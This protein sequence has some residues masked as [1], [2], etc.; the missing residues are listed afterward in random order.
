MAHILFSWLLAFA[1]CLE[2]HRL[3]DPPP[4]SS[5]TMGRRPLGV[6][7]HQLQLERTIWATATPI[8]TGPEA[9]KTGDISTLHTLSTG[10]ECDGA[11][12]IGTPAPYISCYTKQMWL[13]SHLWSCPLNGPSSGRFY[14][15][16]RHGSDQGSG[17]G[18]RIAW[19]S[20][21]EGSAEAPLIDGLQTLFMNGLPAA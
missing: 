8:L 17:R 2:S 1:G 21:S 9:L 18:F 14:C 5:E 11:Y 3:W 20:L 12:S 13:C 7:L 15:P 10:V 4:T 6:F 16:P 19:S